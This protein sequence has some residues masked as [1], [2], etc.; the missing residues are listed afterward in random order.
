M[1]SSPSQPGMRSFQ[2]M[3]NGSGV[4]PKEIIQRKGTV[5][6]CK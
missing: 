3:K 1:K 2:Q 5:Q 4:W 6:L